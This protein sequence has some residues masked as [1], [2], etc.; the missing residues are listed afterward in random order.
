M[1]TPFNRI[2]TKSTTLPT[3]EGASRRE[4]Q[5]ERDGVIAETITETERPTPKSRRIPHAKEEE[6]KKDMSLFLLPFK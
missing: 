1:S 5:V 4:G 2:A 6:E 3:S